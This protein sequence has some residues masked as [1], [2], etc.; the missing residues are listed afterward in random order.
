MRDE[1]VI[2]RYARILK[3]EGM[4]A[5]AW[6]VYRQFARHI[7]RELVIPE[8]TTLTPREL[9]RSCMQK[10]FCTAFTSFV[11]TYER[12]RYGGQRSFTA[13]LE[14]ETRMHATQS[15]LEDELP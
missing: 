14:F 15:E 4:S 8:H 3:N 13:Q 2:A 5:A 10:P 1:P 9:A 7:A 6:G 11:D 12:I